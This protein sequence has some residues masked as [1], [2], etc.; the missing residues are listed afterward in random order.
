MS[1][2]KERSHGFPTLP[3]EDAKAGNWNIDTAIYHCV[4]DLRTGLLAFGSEPAAK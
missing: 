1:E 2:G 4:S 3:K